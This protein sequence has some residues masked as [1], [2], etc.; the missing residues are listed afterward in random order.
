MTTYESD[1][2]ETDDPTVEVVDPQVLVKEQISEDQL[3]GYR[4]LETELGGHSVYD[5]EVKPLSGIATATVL[6]GFSSQHAASVWVDSHARSVDLG[7][8]AV[9][10]AARAMYHWQ[11]H[12]GH[13]FAS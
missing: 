4:V 10:R 3:F 11:R 8:F 9:L 2:H 6:R 13:E 7:D 12:G 5:I 1:A